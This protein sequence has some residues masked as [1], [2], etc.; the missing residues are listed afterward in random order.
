MIF[1]LYFEAPFPPKQ[2][3]NSKIKTRVP[4]K[5]KSHDGSMGMVYLY[6]LIYQKID[7]TMHGLVGID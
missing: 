6:L 3:P 5:R 1:V 2:G 7:S 4:G